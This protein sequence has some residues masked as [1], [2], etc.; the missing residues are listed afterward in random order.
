MQTL[1]TLPTTASAMQALGASHAL[2]ADHL[3]RVP[4][5]EDASR[6]GSITLDGRTLVLNPEFMDA[7]TE[8]QRVYVL[9][10]AAMMTINLSADRL[11]DRVPAV[12]QLAC[13]MAIHQQLEDG[14]FTDRPPAS[15][16]LALP[17]A[18]G[19]TSEQIYDRLMDGTFEVYGKKVADFIPADGMP[20]DVT[21]IQ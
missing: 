18:R 11:G 19:L 8:E 3:A 20:D 9:G 13:N 17:E 15:D 6:S 4:A 14:G 5:V 12:W 16:G 2:L 21:T 10:F 7:H 1:A